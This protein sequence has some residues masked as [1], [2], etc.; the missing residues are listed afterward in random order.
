MLKEVLKIN[1]LNWIEE[2]FKPQFCTSEEFIYDDMESQSGYS[3][4]IIYKTFD[5]TKKSHWV[6][7]GHLYDFL[8]STKGK[9]KKLLDF[10]PGDGWPSLI[11]APYV[12]EVIGLDSSHS[13][14]ETCIENAKRLG[15]NN[16]KFKYYSAGDKIPF[17]DN[18]FDGIMAASAIEQTPDPKKILKELFRALKSGGQLRI[19]YESL[20]EYK[21]DKEKGIWIAELKNEKCRMILFNR[22]INKEF[23]IQYGITLATSKQELENVL[24]KKYDGISYE[25]ITVEFLDKIK[26]QIIDVNKLRTTHPSGKTYVKWLEEMGFK[27]VIPS[28]SGGLAAA[29][30]YEHYKDDKKIKEVESVDKL[31]RPTV[32]IVSHL[33]API[34]KNPPITAIK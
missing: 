7:R 28:Y 20:N 17:D 14:V 10:G 32:K 5:G 30:L 2:E 12:R 25:N 29:N 18:T 19:S 23:V 6:D 21:K 27:K 34:E 9:G 11:I 26:N 1:I 4:P 3:L 16:A 13:R 31:I 33:E 22:N 15:I 24:S 8:Y